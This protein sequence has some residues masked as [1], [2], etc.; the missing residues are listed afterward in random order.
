M[1][2]IDGASLTLEQTAGV[3]DGAEVSLAG[4]ARP[5]IERARRFVEDIVASGEVVYGI[6]TGFGAL[7]DVT[8]PPE[9]LRE[10]QVNLVRSHSCGVGEPLPE[11]VVRAMMLQRANVL[12]KGYSGCRI[13]VIETLLRMLNAGCIRSSRRAAR[14][15]R[16]V[17]WRR[18]LIWRSSQSGK[19]MRFKVA[20]E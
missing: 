1:I 17:I 3:A 10:L 6:N 14:S 18:W 13:E 9:K 16:Q 11:R 4:S 12:A 5:R 2:E 19:A 15:E 7:S 20:S 8:I